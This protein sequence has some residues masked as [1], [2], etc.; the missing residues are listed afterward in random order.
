MA[1]NV[2]GNSCQE[3]SLGC[4]VLY[5]IL[6]GNSTDIPSD[7]IVLFDIF[8]SYK[9]KRVMYREDVKEKYKIPLRTASRWQEEVINWGIIN[10][11]ESADRI[12]LSSHFYISQGCKRGS[13]IRGLLIYQVFLLWVVSLLMEPENMRYKIAA[14]E[15][16]RLLKLTDLDVKLVS[17]S[18]FEKRYQE[19]QTK[20]N[21]TELKP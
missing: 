14:F 3:V 13:K 11:P 1:D 2:A 10:F 19:W 5:D 4:K 21:T 9:P 12:L 8:L 6:S 20:N 17:P 7:V 16:L 18:K 15:V